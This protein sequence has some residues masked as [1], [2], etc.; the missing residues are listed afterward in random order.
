MATK[1]DKRWFVLFNAEGAELFSRAGQFVE[2]E[3]RNHTY[4]TTQVKAPDLNHKSVLGTLF[5]ISH[6]TC[7]HSV[8]TL[9]TKSTTVDNENRFTAL[10]FLPIYDAE[11]STKLIMIMF[12]AQESATNNKDYVTSTIVKHSVESILH[13]VHTFMKLLLGELKHS[14]VHG[15]EVSGFKRRVQYLGE[16]IDA[17]LVSDQSERGLD[18]ATRMQVS[19]SQPIQ[20]L[21]FKCS[22]LGEKGLKKLVQSKL[23]KY[24]EFWSVTH[25]ALYT[26]KCLITGTSEWL[27]QSS[28]ELCTL[29]LFLLF[30]PDATARDIPIHY[31]NHAA[32]LVTVQLDEL[33]ELVMI[34]GSS[35][36]VHQ[37]VKNIVTDDLEWEFISRIRRQFNNQLV[38]NLKFDPSLYCFLLVDR[39]GVGEEGMKENS[40]FVYETVAVPSYFEE[41]AHVST[42]VL[43]P[44]QALENAM[45]EFY[46]T[47]ATKVFQ[48]HR[49]LSSDV[50]AKKELIQVNES[51]MLTK[52]F[53]MCA[54]RKGQR[55]IYCLFDIAL[56]HYA[57]M[58][59]TKEIFEML[60]GKIGI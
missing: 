8:Q 1:T 43:P 24:A 48:S 49:H 39:Q 57:L 38:K 50:P 13:T 18:L 41:S 36:S 35:P 40:Y 4:T 9:V 52:N 6:S 19:I 17:L 37:V 44:S 14:H 28:S 31:R 53:A 7:S 11:E 33:T 30:L 56:P 23:Q 47:T 29:G 26:K 55:E 46:I 59:V 60:Q 3:R 27:A 16:V 54:I 45:L 42:Q 15:S 5:N 20:I 12:I 10:H 22:S 34:C 32:R 21:S 2:Y 58:G 51:Y 25:V